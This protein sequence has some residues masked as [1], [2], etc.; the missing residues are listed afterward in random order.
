[1]WLEA[2]NF[3][4]ESALE[5]ALELQKVL[6]ARTHRR[7]VMG[8]EVLVPGQL[9]EALHLPRTISRLRGKQQRLHLVFHRVWSW[10]RCQ[11]TS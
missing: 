3:T 5:A 2:D 9:G 6:A 1:M 11:D 4:V 10:Y 8:Q 7:K